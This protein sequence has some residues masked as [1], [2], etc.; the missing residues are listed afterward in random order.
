MKRA[1]FPAIRAPVF[2]A[3]FLIV[4]YYVFDPARWMVIVMLIGRFI[5][6]NLPPRCGHDSAAAASRF[7]RVN[8]HRTKGEYAH[9]S[10]SSACCLRGW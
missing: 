8:R 3:L 10:V 4:G 7:R 9:G 1:L 5:R 6:A 2:A